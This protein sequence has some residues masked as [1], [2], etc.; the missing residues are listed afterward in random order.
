MKWPFLDSNK[1][2]NKMQQFHKFILLLDDYID[3]F[4]SY[5]DARICE[6]QIDHFSF[7]FFQLVVSS[8]APLPSYDHLSFI[9]FILNL[10]KSQIC[11]S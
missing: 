3:L 9:V 2:T 8:H 10:Q 4:E 11:Y 1:S 5:D 6:C 7:S